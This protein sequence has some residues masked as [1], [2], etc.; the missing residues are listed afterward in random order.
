MKRGV[1]ANVL[2]KEGL[3]LET[4]RTEI[5]KQIGTGPD[6]TMTGSLARTPRAKRVLLL[7]AREAKALSHTFVGTEHLLLG[8]LHEGDGTAARV[9]KVFGVD[10]ENTREIILKEINPNQNP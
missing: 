5:E 7:A 9:L 6:Q 4:V 8:I 3:T 10:V 1:A 2:L